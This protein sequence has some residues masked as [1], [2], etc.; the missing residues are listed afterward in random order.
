MNAFKRNPLRVFGIQDSRHCFLECQ[1]IHLN[2]RSYGKR[3][4][5]QNKPFSCHDKPS[6]SGRAH[7]HS[8]NLCPCRGSEQESGRFLYAAGMLG[9]KKAAISF[10]ESAKR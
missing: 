1:K 2:F 3:S 7:I 6:Q 5:V 4:H 9:I 8:R 10:N